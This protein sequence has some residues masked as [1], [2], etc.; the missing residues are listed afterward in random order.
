MQKWF[1]VGVL[2]P[3]SSPAHARRFSVPGGDELFQGSAQISLDAK[4][5]M[6]VPARHRDT[7]LATCE[8]RVTVT[9]HPDGCLMLF[10]RPV[11]EQHKERIAAWPTAARAFQRIFLGSADDLEM[12]SAGRVLLPATL[13]Q[14]TGLQKE[15][16]LMGMGSHFEIWDA[17]TLTDSEAR[18]IASGAPG[19]VLDYSF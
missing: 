2:R 5:R 11:W 14:A 12:D 17:A 19:V 4:G 7:L 18:A 16:M 3:F 1:F 9:R 8:G 6:T 13:R 10:P 15:L